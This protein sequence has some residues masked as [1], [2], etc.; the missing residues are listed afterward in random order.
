MD[1][2]Y[3]YQKS[4]NK[5]WANAGVDVKDFH[6]ATTQKDVVCRCSKPNNHGQ[7]WVRN[8]EI[9]ETC[10]EFF[11]RNDGKMTCEKAQWR[12][13]GTVLL[14]NKDAANIVSIEGDTSPKSGPFKYDPNSTMGLLRA[15]A[16]AAVDMPYPSP[17]WD[18]EHLRGGPS[19]VPDIPEEV[20][21][22]AR[23]SVWTDRRASETS[24]S[25]PLGT[26]IAP[27]FPTGQIHHTL[28]S[29]R[30]EHTHHVSVATN[31]SQ[32]QRDAEGE[33]HKIPTAPS[34]CSLTHTRNKSFPDT[35][36][37]SIVQKT[38]VAEP[39]Y[40]VRP[41]R[42]SSLYSDDPE[43]SPG[44]ISSYTSE[45][46]GEEQQ[47]LPKVYELPSQHVPAEL[48][49]IQNRHELLRGPTPEIDYQAMYLRELEGSRPGSY[50]EWPG[51]RACT[52][53]VPSLLSQKS[54]KSSLRLS[55]MFQEVEAAVGPPDQEEFLL[56]HVAV[57]SSSDPP[58][59]GEC[60][61][62]K[63]PYND[64]GKRTI[65]IPL[66]G[67]FLHEECLI[68]DFRVCDES[69][70]RCPICRLVLCVRDLADCLET[71]RKAIFG[72]Q[73]TRRHDQ[74]RI[75]F[76]SRGQIAQLQSEEEVAAAQ[77]R[78]LKDYI[79]VH[80][81]ECLHQWQ[82]NPLTEP[83]WY[84]EVIQ[85][86][87][88]LFK[89]WNWQSQQSGYFSNRDAFLMFFA[90]AELARLMN[91]TKTVVSKAQGSHAL[92]PSLAELHCKLLWSKDRYEK[93]KKTWKRTRNGV[94]GCEKVA[95]D[96]YDLATSTQSGRD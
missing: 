33:V 83:D 91:V 80:A 32:V 6:Y 29:E 5:Y 15:R 47:L 71:D 72:A 53:I 36:G 86:V 84:G 26:A 13:A 7:G 76:Q 52:R 28:T 48:P 17:R 30:T 54:M 82:A 55:T 45:A 59:S 74:V 79:D 49:T 56:R 96:A 16:N 40:Y 19:G 42:S 70:G 31:W 37:A 46:S 35:F 43:V 94:L 62:C 10:A 20:W 25:T 44:M 57:C 77:L 1:E 34:I 21:V 4:Q 41:R 89:G 39:S 66:C 75:E 22:K 78:L 38:S 90:W 93:E 65:G 61:L 88:R 12:A 8:T 50:S 18:M 69:I 58:P 73:H 3:A 63:K 11:C 51:K 92:F 27:H 2:L 24:N 68:T 81:D 95:Q 85:P 60:S 67:H 14:K 64:R 9:I 23:P 87:I